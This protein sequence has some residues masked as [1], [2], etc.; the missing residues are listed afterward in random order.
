MNYRVCNL[1]LNKAVTK[2]RGRL[3][4]YQLLSPPFNIGKNYFNTKNGKKDLKIE[5]QGVPS[6]NLTLVKNSKSLFLFNHR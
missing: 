1:Q 2:K 6:M 5:K 4:D 3:R